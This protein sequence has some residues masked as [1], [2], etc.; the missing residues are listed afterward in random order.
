VH[1]LKI[2]SADKGFTNQQFKAYCAGI[3]TQTL[4]I[5]YLYKNNYLLV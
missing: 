5:T 1:S 3:C 2:S 4:N